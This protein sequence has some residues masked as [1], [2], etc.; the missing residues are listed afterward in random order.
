[1][2]DGKEKERTKE[3]LKAPK[4]EVPIQDRARAPSSLGG[5]RR[6]HREGE[7][8][9]EGGRKGEMVGT[10]RKGDVELNTLVPGTLIIVNG[11]F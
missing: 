2:L 7:H 3:R 1:M 6:G 10:G 11:T 4:T 9:G 8:G 5:E